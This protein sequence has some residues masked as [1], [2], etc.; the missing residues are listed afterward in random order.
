MET[1]FPCASGAEPGT[2][3][4]SHRS[5]LAILTLGAIGV[6]YGDIGTSPL[7]AFREALAQMDPAFVGR[8]EI[9]G[10][11]SLAL[12]ALILVVTLKYVLFLSRADNHGEGGVLSLMALANHG[13]AR[14]LAAIL[15]L[16]AA[17]AA[18]FYGDA[19][20]TPALSVLSAVEGLGSVGP[21]APLITPGVVLGL[22][23]AILVALFAFQSHGTARVAGLFGPVCVVWFVVLAGMGVLHILDEPAIL[24]AFNP[25]WG[26]RF[27]LAHGTVG[28][29][30]LGAVFLTVTGAEALVADMGHFG[31]GA[32][33]VGW[34]ALVWPAL[35]L[36]Y[37][38]QGA[39]ALKAL[40]AAHASGRAFAN[41]DWFFTMPPEAWRAPLVVLAT[42][43]TIIASQ[44]VITGAY[45]ITSQAIALGLLPRMRIFQTSH[46]ERGQI[47]MPA[48]N[49][50]LLVG[51]IVLVLAFRSSSA[52][53]AAYGIA[54][55][56]TMVITSLLA[57]FVLRRSWGWGWRA[58]V[59]V[60][61]PL[62]AIDLVFFGA[63]VLRVAEGGW[64]P[65][66][67]AGF[68]GLLIAC[69]MKGQRA[70]ARAAAHRAVPLDGLAASWALRAPPI[71]E[72]T[73]VFLSKDNRDAPSAL[74]HSLKHGR[75]LHARNLVLSVVIAEVPTIAE[76][77]RFTVTRID[78]H[79]SRATMAYG[80]MDRI[81]LP[82]DLGR[83]W[84]EMQRGGGTSFYLGRNSLRRA[85]RS[86]L[87]GW[88][89]PIYAFLHRNAADPFAFMAIPANRVVEMGAQVEL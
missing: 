30:V 19:I 85:R 87:P 88:M 20:I 69:W 10:V 81:D 67:V 84:E 5:R 63:N 77:D 58:S 57:A 46:A 45:S 78:E 50:M 74:L 15:V 17:G 37:L 38:G 72:G 11:L 28:L 42:L 1:T 75:V 34:L 8:G 2:A 39:M 76:T 71:V 83:N 40:A 43:A 26:V 82:S 3:Q 6:V 68:V 41:A 48:I 25:L 47:Y 23:L 29:F 14:P 65:L 60:I 7:Y 12:W 70:A 55:T 49:W 61:A 4:P 9:L 51:V 18:L 31:R 73:A 66:L 44:A 36:N 86:R 52:L 62:L 54:V 89:M 59:L 13:G 16:G 35:S 33:Q 79:L 80:Y 64:V 22:T 56:G 32:I 27:L 53:A 21:V 24:G